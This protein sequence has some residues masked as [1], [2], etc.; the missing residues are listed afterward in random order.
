MRR[1]EEGRVHLLQP[2]ADARQRAVLRAAG[3]AVDQ[4]QVG[5]VLLGLGLGS[6]SGLGVDQQQVGQVLLGLGFGLGLGLGVDQQEVGQVL[7]PGG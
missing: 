3:E 5:Q 2:R 1:R 6:G 4:Q 7:R